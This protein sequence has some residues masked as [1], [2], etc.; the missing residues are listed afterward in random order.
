MKLTWPNFTSRNIQNRKR[1][2]ASS[3]EN[4]SQLEERRL[5]TAI[6]V[7]RDRLFTQDLN[8]NQTADAV[9]REFNF[10]NPGDK[11]VVGDWNGDGFDDVGVFRNGTWYLDANGNSGWD[12]VAG[13]DLVLQF[14]I[15]GDLPYVGDW[16][17]N[18]IDNIGVVRNGYFYLDSNGNGVWENFP[19][20]YY[21]RFGNPSDIPVAGDW[22]GFGRDNIG[23]FRDGQ[24]YLDV[25]GNGLWESGSDSRFEFGI[26]GDTP[27]IG[28]WNADF[29]SD[30]GVVRNGSWYLDANGNR[31]W[32]NTSG[33]DLRFIY[34]N[35]SDTPLIGNWKPRIAFLTSSESSLTDTTPSPSS[36]PSSIALITAS[37]L[38]PPTSKPKI[39]SPPASPSESQ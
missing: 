23:V 25:N 27:V 29:I 30:V 15:P 34:G 14:G 28:D 38:A 7:H 33:G 17:G 20:D 35:A 21:G 31:A 11:P 10:G 8:D 4:V 13:G 2:K 3:L 1:R 6:G 32:N 5:L 24:F 19:A 39:Y 36:T 12:G 26:A 18:G 37:L 16:E 9:D 22:G